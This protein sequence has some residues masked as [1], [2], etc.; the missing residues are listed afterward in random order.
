MNPSI[1]SLATR[2]PARSED[3]IRVTDAPAACSVIAALIP[4]KPAPT[5]RKSDLIVS[6]LP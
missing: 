6:S 2:P 4:A 5:T 1:A 3:S